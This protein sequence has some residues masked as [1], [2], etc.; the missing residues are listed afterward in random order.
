MKPLSNATGS[1]AMI[2]SKGHVWVSFGELLET[3]GTM[4]VVL[5]GTM[6]VVVFDVGTHGRRPRWG[7]GRGPLW[8]NCRCLRSSF[9]LA[10]DSLANKNKMSTSPPRKRKRAYSSTSEPIKAPK[11]D[12]L[13]TVQMTPHEA[14][15][16]GCSQ[17]RLEL[18][19]E[20]VERDDIQEFINERDELGIPAI[21]YTF[22]NSNPET[23]TALLKGMPDLKIKA[24]CFCGK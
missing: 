5:V 4:V 23:L 8:S 3:D 16:F 11:V 7:N 20:M 18:V 10:I 24:R 2:T 15:I 21:H 22:F 17:N 12:R 1:K 9:F 14:L 19:K 13:V 6:V